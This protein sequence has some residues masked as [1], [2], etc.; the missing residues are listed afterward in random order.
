MR[1]SLTITTLMVVQLLTSGCS[2]KIARELRDDD[3]VPLIHGST[4]EAI[5][6]E[7]GQPKLTKAKS[8]CQIAIYGYIPP[9]SWSREEVRDA[10][11]G[12]LFFYLMAEPF[13]FIYGLLEPSD[14]L[15]VVYD[16]SGEVLRY[17]VYEEESTEEALEKLS[18]SISASATCSGG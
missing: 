4:R 12:S 8:S 2:Y 14:R 6:A 10:I 18:A 16:P 17:V 13:A 3:G 5:E 1:F 9:E 11:S 15:G 7:L